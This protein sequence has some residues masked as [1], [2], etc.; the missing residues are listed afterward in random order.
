MVDSPWSGVNGETRVLV[1]LALSFKLSAYLEDMNDRSATIILYGSYG[2]TGSLIADECKSKN[3]Q[4]ILSGR[5]RDALEVQSQ[6]TGFPFEVV[7]LDDSTALM[8]LLLNGRLVIHCAG[9]FQH[10]AIAMVKMCIQTQTHYT[11]ITGEHQV[12]EALAAYDVEAKNAGIM[13]LPGTGFDV[14]PSDCLALY[15]RNKLPS[16]RHLV[17]AFINLNG[18]MSRGTTR[19][20][21]EGLGQGSAVRQ[22]GEL[23][24]IPLGKKIREIDFGPFRARCLN[25]PWGDIST[26]WR[27]TGIPN[28]EVYM[29]ASD[30][31]ISAARMSSYLNW[32]FRMDWV[33]T[34]L[35]KRA[36]KRGAGPSPDKRQS[37]RSILWG[38]VSDDAGNSA[39]ATLDTFNGYTL[40]AKASVLIAEKILSNDFKEGY[41]TPATAYGPDLILALEDTIRKG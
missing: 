31:L 21:I 17:L 13:V 22:N 34:F 24:R 16:A 29:A 25:I 10:T 28:I 41:Q 20:M 33:K 7:N 40:T 6:Q 8:R 15:L 9:P 18:G 26:A 3:L 19:T 23:I 5:D 38:S 1:L 37:S 27:S 4:V 36:D 14:V 39:T 32:L 11:D 30:R 35:R 2:Y 12:F